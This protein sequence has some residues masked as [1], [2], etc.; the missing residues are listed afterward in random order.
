[1]GA[2]VFKFSLALQ[3]AEATAATGAV[4]VALNRSDRRGWNMLLFSAILSIAFLAW[5]VQTVANT[6]AVQLQFMRFAYLHRVI[7]MMG[8]SYIEVIWYPLL[9]ALFMVG[10]LGVRAVGLWFVASL[11]K[12]RAAVG[13]FSLFTCMDKLLK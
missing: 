5:G 10:A 2:S 13:P 9:V 6:G 7:E 1:M 12:Q 11:T 8:I 3:I 4:W